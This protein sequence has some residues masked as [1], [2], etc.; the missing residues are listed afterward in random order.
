M[1]IKKASFLNLCFAVAAAGV[2]AYVAGYRPFGLGPDFP[3]YEFFYDRLGSGSFS[4]LTSQFR[5]EP[6][7]LLAAQYAKVILQLDVMGFVAVLMFV[8]IAIKLYCFSGLKYPLLAFLFYI[9]AWFP[10]HENTQIRA[11]FSIS[12]MFLASLQVF[13]GRWA[14]FALLSCGAYFFHASSLIAAVVLL[15][16]YFL[17]RFGSVFLS[18]A[19]VFASA[20][21]FYMFVGVF[22]GH[23][24]ALR[25]S[26][27]DAVNAPTIFSGV[28]ILGFLFLVAS[29]LSGSIDTVEKRTYFL[30]AC[31]SFSLLFGFYNFPV[32]AHRPRELLLVFMAFIAFDYKLSYRTLA[33]AVIAVALAGWV[34][35]RGISMGLFSG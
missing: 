6:G 15:V 21:L 22:S 27:V 20:I 25:A 11:A 9:F 28:N 5:F 24:M 4:D 3:N 19:V 26:Y 14:Y 31:F 34:F 2:L 13:K 16:S 12:L 29:Y 32:L 30:M 35:Y 17:S 8:S 1:A 7:F 33:Q 18:M 23:F 10:V